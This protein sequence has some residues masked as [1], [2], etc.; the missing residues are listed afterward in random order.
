MTSELMVI[1]G[2][3]MAGARAVI[4]LR[5]AGWTGGITLIGNESL[6][7]YDRPPLSKAA[8]ASATEPQ[9]VLL[10]DDGMIASLK[11]DFIRGNAAT[12]IDRQARAVTLADGR[13]I[14]YVKLLIATGAR[15]RPLPV[16][17]GERALTLR[18]FPDVAVLRQSFTEGRRI[19]IIGGGF[20]GLELASSAAKRGC[21]VT[22][23]EALPR[24]LSRGV[25]PE[26][27]EVV[28]QRHLKAGVIIH[29]GTAIASLSA[30]GVHLQDGRTVAADTIIAGIGAVPETRLAAAAGLALDNGIA[31]DGA[32]RTSDPDIYAAGDCCSFPHPLFGGKRMRLEAWRNATDQANVACENMVGGNKT[33]TAVPWFWSDQYELNLQIAGVPGEG[34]STVR[35]QL[36]PESFV[37]FHRDANGRLTG[38][39]GI[40]PGNTIARDVR[41]AEML[42]GKQAAPA[43]ELL[44]DP[45]VALKSLL[46]P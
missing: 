30:E 25:P 42:I 24:I 19:A 27:A 43:V 5:A 28:H 40:G 35:R 46:K 29:T 31:C 10:L 12:V 22:L 4:A 39:S 18:D 17:G 23:I 45:A 41:M 36:G 14:P 13:I 11:A 34:I 21:A 26:I 8:I 37:I 32:M 16:P 20:I 2:A 33:Y 7:P 15:P 9:P 44:Q 1:I 38:A 3:G 6:P